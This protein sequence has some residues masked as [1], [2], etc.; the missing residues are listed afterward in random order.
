MQNYGFSYAEDLCFS[1]FDRME[2]QIC[3][4]FHENP[5]ILGHLQQSN[6]HN[7]KYTKTQTLKRKQTQGRGIRQGLLPAQSSKPKKL[8]SEGLND[9][10]ET[11]SLFPPNQTD[12]SHFWGS[13][14]SFV[15]PV[16]I[17]HILIIKNDQKNW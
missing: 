8:G 5:A 13:V 11:K 2:A 3:P 12:K 7:V 9:S 1:L 15:K 17:A 6:T 14:H 10:H 16:K 4:V